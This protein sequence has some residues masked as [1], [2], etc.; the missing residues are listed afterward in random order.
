MLK[1]F[2]KLLATFIGTV[3]ISAIVVFIAI[4]LI[5]QNI[6]PVNFREETWI[7]VII[8]GALGIIGGFFE[9]IVG[10][11]WSGIGFILGLIVVAI[12]SYNFVISEDLG[13]PGAVI[14]ETVE[15]ITN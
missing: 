12:F 13:F 5:E 10:N 2:L 1:N 8:I 7:I 9:I 15:E 11:A 14:R 3:V 6:I 4:Y